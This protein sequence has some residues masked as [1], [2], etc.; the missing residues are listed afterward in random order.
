MEPGK[1]TRDSLPAQCLGKLMK[2]SLIEPMDSLYPS[3]LGNA[4]DHNRLPAIAAAGNLDLLQGRMLGLFCSKECPGDV[5][6]R[7]Y[8]LV[9]ALRDAGIPIIGGFHSPMEKE[10]LT[11]LVRGT[12]PF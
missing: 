1:A 10:C 7:I 6:L 2:V 4:F 9:R 5:I 8:D 12:E 11:L 3:R